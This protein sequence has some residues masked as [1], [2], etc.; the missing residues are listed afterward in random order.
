M[1]WFS[2]LEFYGRLAES[3]NE[4][5]YEQLLDPLFIRSVIFDTALSIFIDWRSRVIE[6]IGNQA[7]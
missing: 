1:N 3:L 5:S 6:P 7:T 2:K 4:C